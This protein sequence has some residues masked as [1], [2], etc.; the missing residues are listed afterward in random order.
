[1]RGMNMKTHMVGALLIGSLLLGG[2]AGVIIG[3]GAGAGAILYT[4][5]DSVRSYEYPMKKVAIAAQ[6][7]FSDLEISV[8]E[9][10]VTEIESYLAGTMAN[11]VRVTIEMV[12]EHVGITEVSIRV[13][14]LG[15]ETASE[16][17]HE[18]LL[19]NLR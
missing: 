5:G 10:S 2:C 14:V 18:Q 9:T 15:D 19:S 17:I 4:K 1:M 6:R 11:D 3:A 8:T 7:T 16:R 13:G 12:S